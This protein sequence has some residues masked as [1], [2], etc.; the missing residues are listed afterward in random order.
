[1]SVIT[2]GFPF[3]SRSVARCLDTDQVYRKIADV[4]HYRQDHYRG[5]SLPNKFNVEWPT[6]SIAVPTITQV[7][8][9]EQVH[10]HTYIY[11]HEATNRLVTVQ[12][13]AI[14]HSP[15]FVRG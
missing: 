12:Y 4:F 11:L 8:R 3:P 1:M 10:G 7:S 9:S 14:E 15:W 13:T 6:F 5:V 2:A